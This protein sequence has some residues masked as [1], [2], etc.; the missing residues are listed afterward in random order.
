VFQLKDIEGLPNQEVADVLDLSL[1]AVK[2]RA[3]RARLFLRER[4][5]DYYQEYI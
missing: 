2:S 4:L 5:S 1:P 3:L